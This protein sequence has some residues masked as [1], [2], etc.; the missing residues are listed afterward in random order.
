MGSIGCAETSVAY[1]QSTLLNISELR[2]CHLGYGRSLKSHTMQIYCKKIVYNY[3]TLLAQTFL[4]IFNLIMA[5]LGKTHR[6]L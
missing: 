2:R 6:I 4:I 5:L 3:T 1:Y